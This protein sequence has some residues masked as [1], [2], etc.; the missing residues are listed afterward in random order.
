MKYK[1][2]NKQDTLYAPS[3]DAFTAEQIFKKYPLAK[4]PSV[5]FIICDAPISM[6]V[7]MEY[8]QTAETYKK[9]GAEIT[10][11]MS[12]QEV[13]DAITAFEQKPV[14][15]EPTAEER[16]AAAAEYQNLINL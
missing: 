1:L 4:L 14:E 13:L 7:F 6:G 10:D 8:S 5:D 16:I 15:Q 11:G 2:W 3:G 12:K 9:A